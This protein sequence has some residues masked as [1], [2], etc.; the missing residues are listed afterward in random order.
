MVPS[1]NNQHTGFAWILAASSICCKYIS[2]QALPLLLS[3]NQR[4]QV[5]HVMLSSDSMLL[6]N[7]GGKRLL[8]MWHTCVMPLLHL[9][10][11]NDACGGFT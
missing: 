7:L 8:F 2:P 3:Y 10:T 5:M 11:S 9:I 4:K 6:R 1:C